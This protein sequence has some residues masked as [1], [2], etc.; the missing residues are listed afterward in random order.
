MA[1]FIQ[2]IYRHLRPRSA[3]EL[4]PEG[5]L[6][7]LILVR[8]E[9]KWRYFEQLVERS[10]SG[11]RVMLAHYHRLPDRG[12]SAP[13]DA[14]LA[15]LLEHAER[16]VFAARDPGDWRLRLR[17]LVRWLRKRQVISIYTGLATL[18][19]RHQ[20]TRII[21]WNGR[22]YQDQ[23]LHLLNRASIQVIFFENGVLPAT[24]TIDPA[25]INAASSIPRDPSVFLR[26]ACQPCELAAIGDRRGRA[27][28]RPRPNAT[29]RPGGRV[30]ILLPFQK[31]R[32]SQLLDHSPW[33]SSMPELFATVREAISAAGVAEARLWVR[34]H[35]SS[36]S[37]YPKLYA[38]IST[39]ADCELAN[40]GRLGEW[41]DQMNLVITINSTVGLEALLVGKSVIT[42]GEA[43]YAIP[44]LA[45]RARNAKE[46]VELIRSSQTQR[47]DPQVLAGFKSYLANHY[48]VAGDWRKPDTAH[49]RAVSARLEGLASDT[50]KEP[51][52][53]LALVSDA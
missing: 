52:A 6:D 31:E 40:G 35:P 12:H 19:K 29:K 33:I 47:T 34:E 49:W 25:G 32:D 48:A 1:R 50:S 13:A 15:K 14:E 4:G 7:L 20:P 24:T 36:A 28:L 21:V 9:R 38:A 41:L 18:L 39:D 37:R 26:H 11:Q 42:L 16:E 51:S 5:P 22:K 23:V 17:P 10:L 30:E 43:F 2:S 27:N 3:K 45:S 53:R 8:S 46:L 44:G